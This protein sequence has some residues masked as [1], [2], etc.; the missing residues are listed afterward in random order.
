M[1][2]KNGLQLLALAALL[3][4]LG[5]VLAVLGYFRAAFTAD[6]GHV[7]TVLRDLGATLA[8]DLGHVLAILG[9]FAASLAT[10]LGMA[11]GVAVPAASGMLA[12][13]RPRGSPVVRHFGTCHSQSS[14]DCSGGLCRNH[15]ES[16][17]ARVE[18]SSPQGDSG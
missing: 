18:E 17:P 4:D 3:T 9:D 2:W 1:F 14:P 5:H 13:L 11:F 16:I 7:L 12:S 15:R 6:R 10:G 8:A